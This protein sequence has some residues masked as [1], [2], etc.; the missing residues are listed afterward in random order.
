MHVVQF[1]GRDVGGPATVAL[2]L[3]Q[4]LHRRGHYSELFA[5]RREGASSPFAPVPL[6]GARSPAVLGERVLRRVWPHMANKRGRERLRIALTWAS[7]PRLAL[8]WWRGSEDLA[9]PVAQGLLSMRGRPDVFLLHSV[10][11][12]LFNLGLIRELAGMAPVV[13]SLHDQ[14]LMTGHCAHSHDCERWRVGCGS[15]PYLGTFPAIRRDG[16]RENFRRK[17]E[18]VAASRFYIVVPCRWLENKLR[19]SM[20]WP[21]TIA[22]RVIH[23]GVDV[24]LF[25]PG[26]RRAA[27]AKLGF[28]P[29]TL[30]FLFVA[31]EAPTNQFKD[32][33]LFLAAAERMARGSGLP[34]VFVVLGGRGSSERAMSGGVSLIHR[35]YTRDSAVVALYYQAADAYLHPALA[36]T[37][38]LVVLEALSS[39]LPVVASDVGGIAEQVR[40]LLAL[41]SAA[42]TTTERDRDSAATGALIRRG[43]ADGF[44]HAVERLAADPELRRRLGRNAAADARRRFDREAQIDSY[45]TWLQEID[46]TRRRRP[47]DPR[48][49]RLASAAVERRG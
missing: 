10:L 39:G 31:V 29:D 14:W 22:A 8:E 48:D 23:S 28:P 6:G 18:F 3:H 47:R 37:F 20:L 46:A 36:E 1:T 40:P 49:A 4:G 24:A 15:C 34:A 35:R 32:Y 5:S 41:S 43:D 2:T 11:P 38:P 17:A 26:D 19:A 44:A 27:R 16:T 21:S 12:G 42:S 45:V 13:L 9:A 30:V 33:A 25:G 7:R